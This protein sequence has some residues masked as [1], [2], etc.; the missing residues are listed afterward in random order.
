MA[1]LRTIAPG[2]LLAAPRLGDP[3]FEHTVVLLARHDDSGALGWV[4][5]G[6]AM[7]P[8]RE[9]LLGAG[10]VPEGL[11]LP[12]G[13]PF[14][15]PARVGGPV[16]PSTGWVLYR[17]NHYA[18]DGEIS[19]GETLA[20]T[21]DRDALA[22]VM[23][24]R[25]RDFRLFLGYAGWSPGQLESEVRQGVW[26]PTD[27][28]PDLVFDEAAETLWTEAYRSLV[29]MAPAAFVSGRGGSA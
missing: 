20:V 22:E 28:D 26:L 10:L 12:D 24:A 11:E 14:V 23:R 16:S 21:G 18:L 27:I 4:L 6:K 1:N 17:K 19:A 2:L 15:R 9:L 8:V 3:N 29:G 5:N 13:G 7:A 25:T